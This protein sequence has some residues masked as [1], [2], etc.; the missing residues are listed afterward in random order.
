MLGIALLLGPAATSFVQAQP[1]IS[2]YGA[3]SIA[4]LTE[5]QKV[6]RLIEWVRHLDGATFIRNGEEYNCQQAADH[7]Q[8]KWEKHKDEVKT[9]EEFIDGLASKSGMTGE[10]YL[11]RFPDGKTVTCGEAL[12]QQLQ[13]IEQS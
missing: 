8:S 3:E 5:P 10:D 11:I 1:F 6:E 9:A 2:N 4:E 7:L 13:R 12:H